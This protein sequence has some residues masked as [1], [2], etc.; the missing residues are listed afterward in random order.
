MK[1]VRTTILTLTLLAAL[2]LP[3]FAQ[4]KVATVDM[5]K[6]FSAY[7]KTKLAT[8]ALDKRKAE[9]RKDIKEMQDGLQKAQADYKQMAEQ[10]ADPAISADE[11][12][13][14]NA[15]LDD[16]K[17]DIEDRRS[18]LESYNRQAETQLSEQ[19][20]RMSSNLVGEIQKVV[21]DK[22]KAA[23]YG[24]VLN[25]ATAEVVVYAAAG[26]DDLT[27]AVIKDLNAGAPI[28]VSTPAT[29]N[30]GTNH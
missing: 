28:D 25:S 21:A 8:D 2:T 30:N 23:G 3:A 1:I 18:N 5:R 11:R 26:S 27:D 20:Q 15:A 4:T 29:T 16:K 13:K 6:I 7:Y 10:A 9:L 14:R 17:K 12:A 24:L 19:S 22:A